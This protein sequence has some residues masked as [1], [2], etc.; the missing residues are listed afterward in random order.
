MFSGIVEETA[1]VVSLSRSSECCRLALRSGLDHRETRIGDSI[2]VSGVCLTVVHKEGAQVVFDLSEETLRRSTLGR[3][4]SGDLINVERSLVLGERIHGHLVFGHVDTLVTLLAREDEPGS[5]KMTWS[6][7]PDWRRFLT[8]K[9]SVAIAGVSLTVGE[10]ETD[11]FSVYLIP[12][13]LEVTTLSNAQ[14]G[15]SANL[16]VDM[17][18]RYVAAILA[19]GW[20][21]SET[22]SKVTMDFLKQHGFGGKE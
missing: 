1:K 20:P 9:G 10:V 7:P 12:H 19:E 17:L 21:G 6:L 3:L 14:V 4:N 15:Y 5:I 11:R 22:S 2:C 18:A 16:E 13:T 8:P